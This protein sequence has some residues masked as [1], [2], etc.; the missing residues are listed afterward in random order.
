MEKN[1]KASRIKIL[2]VMLIVVLA[3]IWGNSLLPGEQSAEVSNGLSDFIARLFGIT[4]ED[5]GII[6]RKAAHFS[7]YAVLGAVVYLLLK[8]KGKKEKE[9]VL[10]CAV[11][12]LLFPLIDETIQL[13]IPQRN[14]AVLDIWI[15]ISG[16]VVGSL[17]TNLCVKRSVK[18]KTIE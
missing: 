15:D 9:L 8:S 18:A 17:I 16:Y 2:T 3:F 5:L 4:T 11:C 10:Y 12:M 1:K 14:G 6:I 7:E 13:I